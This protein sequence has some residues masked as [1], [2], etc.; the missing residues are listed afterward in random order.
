[1]VSLK[2]LQLSC[3]IFRTLDMNIIAFLSINIVH[4]LFMQS[5]FLKNIISIL[6]KE[7]VI[8]LLG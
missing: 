1:M 4:V 3:R 5:N 2:I 7:D 6:L 8:Y